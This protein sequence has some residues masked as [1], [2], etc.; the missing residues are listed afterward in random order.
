MPLNIDHRLIIPELSVASINCNSLNMS[1]SSK[2]N[3]TKKIYGI[4][5]LNT[6]IIFLSDI[7]LC[8][9]NLVS[10]S[11]DCSKAFRINPYC[12]YKFIFNSSMNKRG[13]GILIKKCLDISEEERRTDPEEN[14]LLVRVLYKGTALILG[15][16]YGPNDYNPDFFTRLETAIRSLGDVPVIIGGDWNCTFSTDP[17]FFNI[18]CRNMQNLPNL[19]HSHRVRDL[20]GNLNLTDPYRLFF[21]SRKD[22]TFCPKNSA[23]LN[24]SRIDFFLISIPLFVDA[25]SCDIAPA[26]QNSLFDHK[27]I[28]INFNTT[29]K[30]PLAIPQSLKIL[31]TTVN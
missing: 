12:S 5:K 21:P 13:V 30:K 28:L 18:D 14:F 17:L 11:N 7:R 31:L 24:R 3:Q 1:L 27:A 25:S 26:L 8:N 10:A 6:D 22:F 29:K 4:C 15:S 2:H 20:C 23:Q 19:R 9:K 16:I